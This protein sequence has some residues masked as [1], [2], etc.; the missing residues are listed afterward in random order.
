MSVENVQ[1][2]SFYTYLLGLSA[3]NTICQKFQRNSLVLIV[4]TV[5]PVK[6]NQ[7]YVYKSS[8]ELMYRT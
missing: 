7:V 3:A 2:L 5:K 4:L 6:S 1:S 8:G